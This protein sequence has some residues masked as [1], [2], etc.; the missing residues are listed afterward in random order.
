MVSTAKS[1][2]FPLR[3]SAS[4]SDKGKAITAANAFVVDEFH[5]IRMLRVERKRTER[6]GKPFMLMLLRH[7]QGFQ[8]SEVVRE[9]VS[10]VELS[11]RETD[12]L[13]WYETGSVLGILFTEIGTTDREAIERIV[14]KVE[15]SLVKRLD[16]SESEQLKI[17]Y[18]V[19]PEDVGATKG[20]HTADMNLYPD[21]A[22]MTSQKKGAQAA[23]RVID[24]VGSL[25]AILMLL[26]VFLVVAAA[27]KL[28][29]EGPVF[30]R[31]K[32]IGQFGNTFTFLKFRSMRANNDPKI[33]EEYV[34]KLIAGQSENL[35]QEDGKNGSFK[36][37][38][39]PR[40]TKVGKFIRRTSL[41]ELP[42]FFNVLAGEMS[43]VGPRPPV[44]Y[45]YEAYDI[46]HRRRLVEVKP[47]ITGLWQV[48]GRSKTTFDEMVRLDLQYAKSWT[49]GMDLKLLM[50]T[51]KAV[52]SG[53]GAY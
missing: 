22:R 43:L 31:Q 1:F 26:P 50:K 40:V 19:Y 49:I 20:K 30:F 9:L 5:F 23:K 25:F 18:H 52:V 44:P 48:F 3:E 39:D 38:N 10:G 32:R 46:W 24:I 12:T 37:V 36:L 29:S 16:E 21:L 7:E 33:H 35:K 47:G 15:S 45:E 13:G 42:Q 51:P 8:D 11:T 6:S 34:K 4:T 2:P 14:Q 41:D 17:T 53:D 27:V 28:S